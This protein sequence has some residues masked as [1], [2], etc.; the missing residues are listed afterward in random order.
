MS[1]VAA[2]QTQTAVLEGPAGSFPSV[3]AFMPPSQLCL[4][5]VVMRTSLMFLYILMRAVVLQ[6]KYSWNDGTW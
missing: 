6:D 2:G 4:T 5:T 3:P 1:P